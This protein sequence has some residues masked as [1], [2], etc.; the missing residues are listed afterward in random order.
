MSKRKT[1]ACGCG[2]PINPVYNPHTKQY[3][4]FVKGHENKGRSKKEFLPYEEAKKWMQRLKIQ[5][6]PE[7]QKL[8]KSKKLPRGIPAKPHTVYKGKGWEGLPDFLGYPRKRVDPQSM[9]SYE[10]AKKVIQQL[11]LKNTKK[12]YELSK[13]RKLPDGIP[14]YPN[15]AYK[16]KGWVDWADFLGYMG[17][18]SQ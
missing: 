16:D 14:A 10:D 9:I 5:N 6:L 15:Q 8:S 2:K 11:R 1:C 4:K 18:K 17:N 7:F 3:T 13:Q 12:Y